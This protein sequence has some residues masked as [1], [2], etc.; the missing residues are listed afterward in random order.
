MIIKDLNLN[1]LLFTK[2]ELKIV[3]SL[4]QIGRHKNIMSALINIDPEKEA[5]L[6][7]VMNIL[8]PIND[9]F[10]SEVRK[11]MNKALPNG[12]Q[13]PEEEAE[14]DAKLQAEYKL[15]V[16][17]QERNRNEIEVSLAKKDEDK[18]TNVDDKN[19][20]PDLSQELLDK[21]KEI[22]EKLKVAIKEFRKMKDDKDKKE[23]VK[24][25]KTEIKALEKELDSIK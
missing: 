16:E 14:W 5:E 24:T 3:E 15:F 6:Q 13:S 17:T 8:E 12:P 10:E 21:Q 20:S 22:S 23:E 18:E 9:G 4:I 1:K 19:T 7:R 2:D 11:Q 25:L